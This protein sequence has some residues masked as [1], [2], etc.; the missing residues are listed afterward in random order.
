MTTN[1]TTTSTWHEAHGR[2]GN[3][4]YPVHRYPFGW[5]HV[6][7]GV[8]SCPTL[9]PVATCCETHADYTARVGDLRDRRVVSMGSRKVHRPECRYVTGTPGSAAFP[10]ADK[11]AVDLL[12]ACQAC[13]KVRR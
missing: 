11:G 4:G 6:G 9:T 3:C 10:W 7:C 2:C 5:Q 1:N 12:P 8:F 13:L